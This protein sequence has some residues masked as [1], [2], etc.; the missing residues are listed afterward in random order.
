M[1]ADIVV[2]ENYNWNFE[3]KSLDFIVT[4]KDQ[5]TRRIKLFYDIDQD[6]WAGSIFE[7]NYKPWCPLNDNVVTKLVKLYNLNYEVRKILSYKELFEKRCQ[8]ELVGRLFA[9]EWQ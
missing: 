2:N 4:R 1:N 6:E 9:E 7:H 8:E 3:L 5:G